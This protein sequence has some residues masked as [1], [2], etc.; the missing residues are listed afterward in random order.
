MNSNSR[1]GVNSPATEPDSLADRRS[2]SLQRELERGYDRRFRERAEYRTR[3]WALLI[4]HYFHRFVPED[5][6]VLELGCGW[7]EFINQVRARRRIG[8]DLNPAAREHL[9]P[10]VTFLHQDSST[11]WPVESDSLDTIFTSNFFEHLPE[12]AMLSATLGEALR[13]L[14]PGGRLVSVG[15][16]VR[17]LPGAYWDFWDHYIPL[18]EISLSEGLEI[19]GF[20][21]EQAIARF[22]PYSMAHSRPLPLWM[23]GVYLAL[24]PAWPLFGKQFLVV[25]VKPHETTM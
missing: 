17:L 18:T 2:I 19:A 5:G 3:V 15:P 12:K 23:I 16:N 8:M 9:D 10:G 25:A 11:P 1:T 6:V 14:K 20:R 4:R 24:R 22:L 21:V 13:C 7:G